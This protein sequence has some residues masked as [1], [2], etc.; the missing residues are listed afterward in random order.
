M[1]MWIG[2]R[3][4]VSGHVDRGQG[5]GQWS[6]IEGLGHWSCRQGKGTDHVDREKGGCDWK[7]MTC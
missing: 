3:D 1:V 5:L 4:W 6:C 7:P 2:D